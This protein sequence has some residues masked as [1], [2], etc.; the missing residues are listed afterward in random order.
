MYN[1]QD[2]D[3]EDNMYNKYNIRQAM[4]QHEEIINNKEEFPPLPIEDAK[5]IIQGL[6]QQIVIQESTNKEVKSFLHKEIKE[7]VENL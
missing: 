2:G 4:H 3:V 5:H 1:S 7:E 6:T